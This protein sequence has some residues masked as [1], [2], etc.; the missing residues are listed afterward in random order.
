M[1]IIIDK[2]LSRRK[3]QVRWCALLQWGATFLIVN[4]KDEVF[5]GVKFLQVHNQILKAKKNRI[6]QHYQEQEERLL[7]NDLEANVL[8]TIVGGSIWL[9]VQIV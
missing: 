7:E 5:T 3:A 4:L 1:F 6:L 9:H 8:S 2:V